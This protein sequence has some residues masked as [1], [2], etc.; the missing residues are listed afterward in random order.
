[1]V[2]AEPPS[3][4]PK[5]T[6]EEESGRVEHGHHVLDDGFDRVAAGVAVGE[7]HATL[8]EADHAGEAREPLEEA[9]RTGEL[10]P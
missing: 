6:V 5:I 8:V 9:L 2:A 7:P 4:K 3:D 10:R 1:M